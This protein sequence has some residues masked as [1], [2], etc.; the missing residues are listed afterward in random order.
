MKRAVSRS[1]QIGTWFE[2][3]IASGLAAA[4]GDDRIERRA[5]SGVNDRG[6]IGG[7]RFGPHRVVVE[8]KRIATGKVFHLPEW[9]A[10]AQREAE[11]DGALVGVVIHKRAGTTDPMKQWCSMEVGDLCKMLLAAR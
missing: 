4:L 5:A 9:V 3:S 10:E 1:K 7:V 2:T 8:C 6:D 11:N